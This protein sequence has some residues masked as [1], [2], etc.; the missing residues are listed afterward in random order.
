MCIKA[1]PALSRHTGVHMLGG[2]AKKNIGKFNIK[3]VIINDRVMVM[4]RYSRG[5][6]SPVKIGP[7]LPTIR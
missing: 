7:T 5:I 6:L 4:L 3:L 1:T 2:H